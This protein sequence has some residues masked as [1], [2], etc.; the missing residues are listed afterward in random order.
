MPRSVE[1]CTAGD[2]VSFRDSSDAPSPKRFRK[3]WKEQISS[4]LVEWI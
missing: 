1:T 3:L 2:I 4:R